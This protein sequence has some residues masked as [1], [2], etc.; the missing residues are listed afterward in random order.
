MRDSDP[1]RDYGHG[2]G[3]LGRP[4]EPAIGSEKANRKLNRTVGFSRRADSELIKMPKAFT[5]NRLRTKVTKSM[6]SAELTGCQPPVA[7]RRPFPHPP[8]QDL[9]LNLGQKGMRQ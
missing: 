5:T 7:Y 3:K 6:G 2:L 1:L 9:I 4:Y 8:I